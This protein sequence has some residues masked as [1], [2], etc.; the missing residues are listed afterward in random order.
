MSSFYNKGKKGRNTSLENH[1]I[2]E[3]VNIMEK[4]GIDEVETVTTPEDLYALRDK[5][6]AKYGSAQNTDTVQSK[7]GNIKA[8]TKAP[9]QENLDP[10]PDPDPD[11]KEEF[12]LTPEDEITTEKSSNPHFNLSDFVEVK[13]INPFSAPFKQEDMFK[14]SNEF[15]LTPNEE[16][17][18]T[19]DRFGN[20]P[21]PENSDATPNAW[22][23][24]KQRGASEKPIERL[25]VE[26]VESSDEMKVKPQSETSKK[27]TRSLAKQSAKIF[28]FISEW[29]VKKYSKV[30][31]KHVAGLEEQDLID[32]NFMVNGKTV[33]EL[34][35]EHNDM[36]DELIKVDEDAKEDLVDAL[37]LVAEKHQIEMSPESNLAMVVVTI[38]ISLGKA[39]Y[40]AKQEMRKT[41]RKISD[42]YVLNKRGLQQAQDENA[43]LRAE[44][45]MLRS[46]NGNMGSVQPPAPEVPEESP[47][48]S[49]SFGS[50]GDKAQKPSLSIIKPVEITE[51]NIEEASAELEEIDS[52]VEGDQRPKKKRKKPVVVKPQ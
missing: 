17:A 15:A 11:P 37:M 4:N 34:V 8:E 42:T 2:Q 32:R 44:L 43:Q 16:T 27:A 29:G 39:G 33:A 20:N 1:A 12:T 30:S 7:R 24:A 35:E 38:L 23:I 28:Q 52:E 48:K 25:D 5:L 47:V 3:I 36:I 21:L 50:N 19:H 22:E 40:D 10:V 6:K 26:T 46:N 18:T 41:L 49:L 13:D 31:E 51:R 45:R 9:V 14:A